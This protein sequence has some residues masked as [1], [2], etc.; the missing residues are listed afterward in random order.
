EWRCGVFDPP[1]LIPGVKPGQHVGQLQ[2]WVRM[3]ALEAYFG[4]A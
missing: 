2:M 3:G 1:C 4:E